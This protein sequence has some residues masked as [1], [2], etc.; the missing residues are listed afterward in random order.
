MAKAKKKTA[1]DTKL[2]VETVKTY[3]I[4]DL[5]R[6]SAEHDVTDP[7]RDFYRAHGKFPDAVYTRLF[8]D[9]ARFKKTAMTTGWSFEPLE[10]PN[11][12]EFVEDFQNTIK[13]FMKESETGKASVKDMTKKY[14]EV[15]S[16]FSGFLEEYYP[17]F[18]IAK[19]K[20]IFKTY[21]PTRDDLEKLVK[22][23][24]KEKD[25]E[26]QIFTA[27]MPASNLYVPGYKSIQT[28]MKKTG[29]KL[30]LLPMRGLHNKHTHYEE[31]VAAL[32]EYY[33][34]ELVISDNLVATDFKAFATIPYPLTSKTQE[35][36]KLQGRSGII[37]HPK[38]HIKALPVQDWDKPQTVMTTGFIT[39]REW[40]NTESHYLAERK[41]VLGGVILEIDHK[42][43]TFFARHFQFAA[44][45]SFVDNGT[46]YHP[47]GKVT[48]ENVAHLTV[49]DF[50]IGHTE[51]HA[52]KATYDM[53]KTL[54]VE[55]VSLHDVFDGQ[56]INPHEAHDI[57]AQHDRPEWAASLLSELHLVG[58]TL[59]E[60]VNTIPK[61]VKVD[62]VASN[63]DHFLERY[64]RFESYRGDR[65]NAPLGWELSDAMVKHRKASPTR[66][67]LNP[68]K[69][70]V[71]K[72][73]PN[74][75]GRINWFKLGEVCR[76][77]SKKID[78]AS[79]G[80]KGPKGA[81]G[82]TKNYKVAVGACNIGHHHEPEVID[83]VWVAG[84]LARYF[85]Y[86]RGQP[87]GTQNAN[88]A[89]YDDG[90]RQMLWISKT[91]EWH[92]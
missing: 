74:L 41:S 73:Y 43:K 85:D 55:R 92:T 50:H 62:I 60:F 86:N 65:V 44:D 77:S 34:R 47:D 71:E 19:S 26:I 79:H 27:I 33:V 31:D 66:E 20:I 75:V 2:S 23:H 11:E 16:N 5:R 8:G 25:K 56:S 4:S 58:K 14:Y 30:H 40:F 1:Q 15:N 6:V 76:I 29:A 83:D 48:H 63:H 70:W 18:A 84:T 51:P 42:K 67:I 57:M 12:V 64:L 46:R 78:I 24:K 80:H 87:S 39:T 10:R 28:C 88:I 17:S 32:E 21:G 68:L 54:K 69:Y 7:A 3:V 90:S 13:Q 52:L 59:T 53:I 72:N 37:A 61:N 82:T 89:T 35:L 49:G 91:A 9:F 81:K 36:I 38:Q 45:G 22:K